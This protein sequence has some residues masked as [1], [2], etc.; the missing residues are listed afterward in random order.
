MASAETW[1]D[2]TTEPV[3]DRKRRACPT[4]VVL[5]TKPMP[6][7]A[8]WMRHSPQPAPASTGTPRGSSG[9]TYESG[10]MSR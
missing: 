1:R 5:T 8:S 4:G 3:A 7:A 6:F 10:A 9:D 2:S